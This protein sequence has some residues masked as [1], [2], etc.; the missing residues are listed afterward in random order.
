MDGGGGS[1]RIARGEGAGHNGGVGV[2]RVGSKL[3]GSAPTS[4]H[5]PTSPTHTREVLTQEFF[6]ANPKGDGERWHTDREG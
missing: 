3:G 2:R 5:T 4:T 1:T 6:A